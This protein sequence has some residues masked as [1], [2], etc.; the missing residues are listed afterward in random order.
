MR[1]LGICAGARRWIKYQELLVDDLPYEVYEGSSGAY[2][3]VLD[4]TTSTGLQWTCSAAIV[5]D[6]NSNTDIP[7]HVHCF[8]SLLAGKQKAVRVSICPCKTG[9]PS[10]G[11]T[12]MTAQMF[13]DCMSSSARVLPYSC[14]KQVFKI[15]VKVFD[16][17]PGSRF[18][19]GL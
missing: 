5:L 11:V 15:K 14:S 9:Q 10:I 17:K 13:L 19:A 6:C 12:L 1:G 2:S 16:K 3:S 7:G 4:H 18:L 8:R